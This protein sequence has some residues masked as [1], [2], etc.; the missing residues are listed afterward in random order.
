M[1]TKMIPRSANLLGT[2]PPALDT[3]FSANTYRAAERKKIGKRE[4]LCLEDMRKREKERG[5]SS[6]L[7]SLLEDCLRRG[8]LPSPFLPPGPLGSVRNAAKTKVEGSLS[9]SQILIRRRVSL[10]PPPPHAIRC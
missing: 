2:I 3:G 7:S 5:L 6:T 10:R 1:T 8:A 4:A 9:P